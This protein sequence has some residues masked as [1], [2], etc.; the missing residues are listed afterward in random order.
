M[1]NE[2]NSDLNGQELLPFNSF[3]KSNGRSA[4]CGWRWRQKGWITTINISGRLYVSKAEC[5]RFHQ[6][7]AAGE[8]AQ[9]NK[10]VFFYDGPLAAL[11]QGR[12][13]ADLSSAVTVKN[14][15]AGQGE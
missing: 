1:I 7:A 4:S 2:L 11:V 5:E 14:P 15:C 12:P 6:R 9:K 13:M 10:G 8:F 3:L